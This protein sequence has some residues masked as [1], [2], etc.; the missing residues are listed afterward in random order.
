MVSLSPAV[1]CT[2]LQ[3]LLARSPSNSTML[4][5][6]LNTNVSTASVPKVFLSE[7]IQQL[8]QGTSKLA[9]CIAV[10]VVPNKLLT[11]ISSSD[12]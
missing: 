6:I 5:F 2:T 9:Q 4:M 10:Q 3:S 8:V 12:S 11:F 1:L 7:L